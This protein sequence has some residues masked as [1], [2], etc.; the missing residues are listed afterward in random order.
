MVLGIGL[1]NNDKVIHKKYIKRN[2]LYS[3]TGV[4]MSN[5]KTIYHNINEG[6]EKDGHSDDVIQDIRYSLV[7]VLIDVH[8]AND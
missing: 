3:N 5:A 6:D 1:T 7:G 4:S 8:S 2:L